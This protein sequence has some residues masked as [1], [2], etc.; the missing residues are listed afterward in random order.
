MRKTPAH[1]AVLAAL[2]LYLAAPLAPVLSGSAC[3][4][5]GHD[6]VK[7]GQGGFVCHCCATPAYQCDEVSFSACKAGGDEET[8]AQPP[9]IAGLS[10]GAG[11]VVYVHRDMFLQVDQPREGYR[12]QP[13]KPPSMKTA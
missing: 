8:R 13:L 5:T 9:A 10:D 11:S 3:Q 4:C 2:V 6:R 7:C 1:V 12:S